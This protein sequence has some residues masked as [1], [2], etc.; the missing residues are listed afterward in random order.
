[1]K[2]IVFFETEGWEENF[3]T[4]SLKDYQVTFYQEP[5]TE[6]NVNLAINADII[7][8]FI[9]SQINKNILNQLPNL[10]L[11]TTRSVGSDHIDLQETQ[12]KNI[13][14]CN[15][16]AY[17]DR[18][19]AEHTFALILA[20]SRKI[21][22]AYE[23][24]EK[25]NFDYHGLTGFDL[26]KKTIGIIGGG[27]IGINVAQIAKQGFEMNVLVSDP[28]PNQELAN[29][30]NFTYTDLDTLLQKSDIISLHA[31]YLPSTHHLINQ[32]N[33]HKIKKGAIL[34]NTSRGGLVDTQALLTAL[35][36]GILSGAGLDVL[37]EENEIK[38]ESQLLSGK[39]PENTNL[40]KIIQNH[41]LVARNDVI[42]TPHIAFNSIEALTNILKVTVDNIS[43]FEKNQPINLVIFRN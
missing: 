16:P 29:H 6:K 21:M 28:R 36:E 5:L 13:A 39:L 14:V 33:I 38:E 1:M 15:V 42:I 34:I 22:F 4:E 43:A 23:R 35:N 9:Y 41:Q 27:K 11:I 24:T 19:V 17:G 26:F 25:L 7:S 37:E 18:T 32:E 20:L 12:N 3:L 31:P 2:K 8:V 30:Y 40:I 10:K